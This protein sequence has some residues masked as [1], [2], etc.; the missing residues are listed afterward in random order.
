MARTLGAVFTGLVQ[1]IGVVASVEPSPAGVRLG[2]DASGW[3]HC[4]VVGDSISVSGCCL[5]VTDGGRGAGNLVFDVI[6]QTLAVTILGDLRAG[7]RVNLE[8]AVRADTL[9]GGH[10]VQGHIDGVGVV[11]GTQPD[12]A[13]WRIEIEAPAALMDCIVPKGSIAVDGVSL[14]LA[15]VSDRGF[16][17]AIIPTT[18]EMTTLGELRE[19]ARCN[20]ETDMIARQVAHIV[21][22]F[23]ER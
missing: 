19:G 17:V 12:P 21:R 22:N 14:T 16:T 7:S 3:N 1:H 9:M 10:F 18:L 13:D 8:H 6:S 15:E 5:T 23:R 4:P 20:I 2:V 11:R